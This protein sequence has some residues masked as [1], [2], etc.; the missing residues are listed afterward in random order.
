[1]P[2]LSPAWRGQIPAGGV[3][4]CSRRLGPYTG[5]PGLE[6][7]QRPGAV[8]S[9]VPRTGAG[10]GPAI[11]PSL[12][13]GSGRGSEG[14]SLGHPESRVRYGVS[15]GLLDPPRKTDQHLNAEK[16]RGGP[17][18]GPVWKSLG[19]KG[20]PHLEF[21]PHLGRWLKDPLDCFS[22]SLSHPGSQAELVKAHRCRGPRKGRAHQSPLASGTPG[23]PSDG[24]EG[25]AVLGAPLLFALLA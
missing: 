4:A 9:V 25:L 10:K 19:K 12:C 24:G 6:S 14:S 3:R 2:F 5:K 23:G 11:G 15:G 7:V 18:P 22:L 1:M 20:A 16:G 8:G 17:R 21:L 13:A